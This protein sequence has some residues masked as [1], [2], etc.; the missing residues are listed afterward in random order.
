MEIFENA[1]LIV[2]LANVMIRKRNSTASEFG[3][4]SGQSL[5][6]RYLLKNGIKRKSIRST[7]KHI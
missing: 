6:L 2:Q 3:L 7:Y 5:I 1:K 4:T